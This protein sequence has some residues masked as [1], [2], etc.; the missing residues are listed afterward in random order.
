MGH[1]FLADETVLAFDLETTGISTNSDRIVQL[2]LIGSNS[3]GEPINYETLINPRRAIP[4]GASQVHGIFDSDVKGLPDFSNYAEEIHGMIEDSVIVGHNVRQFDMPLLE[5]EFRR[6]GKLPPRPRAIM[7]T[8]EIVR[9]V[10]LPRPHNLGSLCQRHGISLDNAHTAAADAAAS[11]LL[12]WKLTIDHS[13]MFRKSL[14][15]VE[16]WLVH[17]KRQSDDS[18]LGR[19]ISDLEMLDSLGKIRIDDGHYIVAFGRHRGRHITEVKSIDPSYINW[20]LS[21]SGI[22]DENVRKVLKEYL[23]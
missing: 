22:E 3:K 1:E 21:P 9:R 15:E 4:N 19:S 14:K 18:E 6:I 8:L 23:S 17:G 11:L 16:Q 2:A 5:N 12:F 7:D 13:P 20:L 10:K